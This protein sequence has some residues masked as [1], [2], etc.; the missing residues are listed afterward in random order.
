MQS[1]DEANVTPST[2]DVIMSENVDDNETP[3]IHTTRRSARLSGGEAPAQ[4]ERATSV[5][6]AGS[7]AIEEENHGLLESALEASQAAPE[8]VD[9][10]KATPARVTPATT[11]P[12]RELS[13]EDFLRLGVA[14]T[15]GR[16]KTPATATPTPSMPATNDLSNGM[17]HSNVLRLT[18]LT[19]LLGPPLAVLPTPVV[20]AV[21]TAPAATTAVEFVARFDSP[22][23]VIEIPVTPSALTSD[24]TLL[25]RIQRYANWKNGK[26]ANVDLTFELFTSVFETM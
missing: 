9:T 15:S 10:A 1:E 12:A 22:K 6:E 3:E 5:A 16:H 25:A 17:P 23:G 13:D 26:G 2:F 11:A 8:K 4:T 24:P 19:P 21:Q 20:P 14:H 7:E 18:V